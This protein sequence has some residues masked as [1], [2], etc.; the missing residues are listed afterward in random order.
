MVVC[1]QLLLKI[2]YLYYNYEKYLLSPLKPRCLALIEKYLHIISDPV[3]SVHQSLRW[4]LWLNWHESTFYPGAAPND[5]KCWPIV[6]SSIQLL[7]ASNCDVTMTD[8]SR[9]VSMD[10]LSACND[11]ESWYVRAKFF[12]ICGAVKWLASDVMINWPRAM[13][14]ARNHGNNGFDHNVAVGYHKTWLNWSR[15][16]HDAGG[17][18]IVVFLPQRCWSQFV[19]YMSVPSFQVS[20]CYGAVNCLAS[21]VM[22]YWRRATRTRRLHENY[23]GLMV[24]CLSWTTM[25]ARVWYWT[26]YEKSGNLIGSESGLS[27]VYLQSLLIHFINV[28]ANIYVIWNRKLITSQWAT[29]KTSSFNFFKLFFLFH[30][31]R[32]ST[33]GI[34]S[35]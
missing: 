18:Y 12:R 5:S 34:A 21:D 1:C 7:A 26:N 19:K 14:T 35:I 3:Y 6:T 32:V 33:R 27:F 10:A 17:F 28:C 31:P 20:F 8:Y 23:L 2:D 25:Y 9:V 15:A 24:P 4:F 16:T 13:C 30:D 29:E 22:I 11:V